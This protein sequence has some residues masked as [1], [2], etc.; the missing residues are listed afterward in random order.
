MPF[1]TGLWTFLETFRKDQQKF[2]NIINQKI[3]KMICFMNFLFIG[4]KI[5]TKEPNDHTINFLIGRHILDNFLQINKKLPYFLGLHLNVQPN[6]HF[7]TV[8]TI[9]ISN[10]VL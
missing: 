6:K 8:D 3:C 1:L 4:G 5:M 9:N 7:Y 10:I 2:H